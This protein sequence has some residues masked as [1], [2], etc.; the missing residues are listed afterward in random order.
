MKK[1]LFLLFFILFVVCDNVGKYVE[2]II[3]VVGEWDG[4][5]EVVIG[6]LGNIIIV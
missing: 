2:V 4:V 5:I 1:L 6:F 3:S